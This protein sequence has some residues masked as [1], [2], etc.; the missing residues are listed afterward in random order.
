MMEAVRDEADRA[1]GMLLFD[2]GREPPRPPDPALVRR[3]FVLRSVVYVLSAMATFEERSR[4]FVG[5]LLA[6][7]GRQ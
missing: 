3:V 4:K 5:E 7:H 6:E 1:G 2:E